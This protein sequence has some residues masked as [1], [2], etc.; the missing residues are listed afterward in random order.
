MTLHP[1]EMPKPPKNLIDTL[2]E[3]Y[4]G[5]TFQ[6]QCPESSSHDR[7]YIIDD[8]VVSPKD[9]I[10]FLISYEDGHRGPVPINRLQADIEQF[11][12]SQPKC[13]RTLFHPTVGPVT[14]GWT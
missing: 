8:V 10:C 14:H 7:Q 3:N 13:T 4:V 2:K 11:A 6:H 12:Q 9:D 5:K 1:D